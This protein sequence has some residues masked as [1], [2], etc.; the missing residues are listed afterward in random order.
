MSNVAI[1]V[2]D[3]KRVEPL[4]SSR[5]ALESKQAL[6][7]ALNSRPN[8]GREHVRRSFVKGRQGDPR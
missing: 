3:L 1:Y 4:G 8:S 5:G 7:N 2:V 6:N